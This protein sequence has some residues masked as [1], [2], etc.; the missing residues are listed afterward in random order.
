MYFGELTDGLRGD[1]A[2]AEV[3]RLTGAVPRLNPRINPPP[4]G[5]E[6]V[7]R[8]VLPPLLIYL[9]H[10]SPCGSVSCSL[11]HEPNHERIPS[12]E[13]R[14]MLQSSLLYSQVETQ[15]WACVIR[16]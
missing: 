14:E 7:P 8:Q 4:D 13:A 3:H 11:Y 5:E 2:L 6:D 10:G 12:C 1:E 15:A 9:L 16:N